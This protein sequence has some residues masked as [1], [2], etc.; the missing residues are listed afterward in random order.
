MT[1]TCVI[2][3]Y[4]GSNHPN[5]LSY[6]SEGLKP[7]TSI[8]EENPPLMTFLV[9]SQGFFTYILVCSQEYL[10]LATFFQVEGADQPSH[11]RTRWLLEWTPES[12]NFWMTENEYGNPWW[13]NSEQS[14]IFFKRSK[15]HWPWLVCGL[16]HFF[17]FS[18]ECH[19]PNRRTH[20]FQR[21]RLNHQP[22]DSRV[23]EDPRVR[24][25]S[26]QCPVCDFVTPI[27]HCGWW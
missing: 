10:K 19:H 14:H 26:S 5:S 21:V 20:I 13:R 2:F 6:F 7:L 1:G 12:C 27:D 18:W 25:L 11:P 23:V 4:I 22:D 9:F 8:A 24:R 16:K 17:P 15:M 3:P